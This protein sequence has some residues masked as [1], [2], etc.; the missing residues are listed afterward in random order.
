MSEA[1]SISVRPLIPADAAAFVIIRREALADAPWA[2][3]G[4][5][6]DDLGLDAAHI[7]AQLSTPGYAILGA[8]E[9]ERLVATCGL[10]T[11]RQRKLAHRIRIWG[12]YVTP[13]S[14]GTGAGR[15]VVRA[16]MDLA[17]S[18]P[19]VTSVGLSASER[20]TTAIALYK[21]L[22]FVP[23]GV[24]PGYMRLGGELIDEVHMVCEFAP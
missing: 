12:V 9:G 11:N 17:R 6:E 14:R 18:W 3:S 21:S 4:S 22:G 20:S 24:E 19:G 15:A 23:W 5:P 10:F 2:F 13:S 7:A 1:P 16:A 8:F